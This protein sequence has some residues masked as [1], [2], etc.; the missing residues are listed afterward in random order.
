[1][2]G[3]WTTQLIGVMMDGVPPHLSWVASGGDWGG[4]KD[5]LPNAGR[6]V[7]MERMGKGN[8]LPTVT[9]GDKAGGSPMSDGTAQQLMEAAEAAPHTTHRG[10][11]QC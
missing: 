5:D 11:G 8:F 4:C 2:A 7:S 1:M 10:G 3:D 9:L 6:V